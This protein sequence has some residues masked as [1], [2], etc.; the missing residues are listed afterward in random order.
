MNN[1]EQLIQDIQNLLNSYEDVK[2]TDINPVLLEF[3][4][5]DTLKDIISSLLYQKEQEK[6]VDM[7]WLEQFKKYV[8]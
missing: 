3:M 8:N 7:E 1:K 2:K 4:D 5:E 6:D